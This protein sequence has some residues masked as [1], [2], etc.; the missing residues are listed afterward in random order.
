MKALNGK[1]KRLDD[2]S[3]RFFEIGYLSKFVELSYSL[4]P[5]IQFW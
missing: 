3:K 1:K 2:L 4:Y 5:I